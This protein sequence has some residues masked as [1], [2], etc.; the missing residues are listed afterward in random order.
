MRDLG[1][2][3]DHHL[4]LG[5]HVNNICK[6]ASFAINNIG[7][8]RKYLSQSDCERIIHAFTTSKLDYCNAILYGLS[9]AQLDKLQRIQNTAARIVSKTKKAQH[10]TPVLRSLHWL[11][12][13][14]RIVFKLLLLTYKALNGQAPSYISDLLTKCEPSRNPAIRYQIPPHCPHIW[15]KKLR[16]QVLSSS[17]SGTFQQTSHRTLKLLFP[18]TLLRLNLGPIVLIYEL[19]YIFLYINILYISISA[20]SCICLHTEKTCNFSKCD[21]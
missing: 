3:V 8:I 14:K 21:L 16:R 19:Y 2:I 10:I 7:R 18:Q 17:C 9:Q 11:L 13:H 4:D 1:T 20:Y 5:K 12:I 6:S 15:Y